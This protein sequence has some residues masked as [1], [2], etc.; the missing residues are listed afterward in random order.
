MSKSHPLH[1]GDTAP[2]NDPSAT[3]P[4]AFEA[5]AVGRMAPGASADVGTP[6]P[7]DTIELAKTANATSY[8][9]SL[10]LPGSGAFQLVDGPVTA[11][12]TVNGTMTSI[13]GTGG[14][15]IELVH[16]AGDGETFSINGFGSATVV[17]QAGYGV[18]GVSLLGTGGAHAGRHAGE[19][20]S[21]SGD[22]RP[23]PWWRTASARSRSR[24]TRGCS[25]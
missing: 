18:L 2:T 21:C 12:G 15:S 20:R 14:G 23:G 19:T 16:A 8:D 9:V 25:R 10:G 17:D 13:T 7:N 4:S 3:D 11:N 6:P 24:R 5:F 1:A 22:R